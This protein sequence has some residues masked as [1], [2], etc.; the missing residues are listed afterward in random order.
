MGLVKQRHPSTALLSNAAA[1]HDSL[2]DEPSR[3]RDG[4]RTQGR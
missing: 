3:I 1:H 2:R 4:H